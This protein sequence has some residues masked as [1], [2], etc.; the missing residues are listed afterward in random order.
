MY[1]LNYIAN[2]F[3][4]FSHPI[5]LIPIIIIGIYRYNRNIFIHTAF[6]L[7][8]SIIINKIL[9]SWF[10]IPLSSVLNKEGYAFPSGH[11]QAA[12]IFYGWLFINI[13]NGLLRF[14]FITI[15]CGIGFGLIH[16]GYHNYF[17]II[18]AIGVGTI[19][20]LI[21]YFC[22]FKKLSF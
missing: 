8:I 4:L 13:R 15:L 20:Q 9:K 6:L 21:Y 2:F 5:F 10:A 11:M 1:L 16:Y 12:F 3:L 17:D 22:F 18:G 14:I 19:I 7:L